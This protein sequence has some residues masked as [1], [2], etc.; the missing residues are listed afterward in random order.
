MII[1]AD[2]L[3]KIILISTL[4]AELFLVAIPLI[5]ILAYRQK[6]ICSIRSLWFGMGLAILTCLKFL[7]LMKQQ[8][9]SNWEPFYSVFI[10]VMV[11]VIV[12]EWIVRRWDKW[13]SRFVSI[14]FV[15]GY[16]FA[17]LLGIGTSVFLFFTWMLARLSYTGKGGAI[18]TEAFQQITPYIQLILHSLFNLGYMLLLFS[19]ILIR[20]RFINQPRRIIIL[21]EWAFLLIQGGALI[22]INTPALPAIPVMIAVLAGTLGLGYLANSLI[23]GPANQSA[24]TS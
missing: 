7:F 10:I 11:E 19:F 5:L 20:I 15:M 12:R 13:E 9:F 2:V 21:T 22:A 14:Q 17:K 23:D 18:N 4:V 16:L 24:L 3:P 6:H 8:L 1:P